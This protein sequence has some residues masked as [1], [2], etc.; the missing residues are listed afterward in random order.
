MKVVMLTLVKVG[1][2]VKVVV[3]F[4]EAFKECKMKMKLCYYMKCHVF[5]LRKCELIAKTAS[6]KLK[7]NGVYKENV[8]PP[9]ELQCSPIQGN[10]MFISK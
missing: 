6:L 2:V 8:D 7:S 10:V 1:V 3:K 5:I 9:G 4:M